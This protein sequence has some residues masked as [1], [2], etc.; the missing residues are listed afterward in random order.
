M[1]DAEEQIDRALVRWMVLW[2]DLQLNSSEGQIYRAGM[3]IHG[4]DLCTFAQ[5]LLH[6]QLSET[7]D[8]AHDSMA[9]IHELLK[10]RPK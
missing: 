4:Q 7:G 9:R 8:I 2:R 5:I 6:K 1:S 3:M 10:R